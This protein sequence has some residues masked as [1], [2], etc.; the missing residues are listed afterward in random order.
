MNPSI[1]CAGSHHPYLVSSQKYSQHYVACLDFKDNTN[2]SLILDDLYEIGI[3]EFLECPGVE[4]KSPDTEADCL[5]MDHLTSINNFFMWSHLMRR[6]LFRPP[7]MT[8]IYAMQLPWQR[9]TL[10][11]CDH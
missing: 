8:C 6:H 4:L 10:C 3:L 11:S 5:P 7:S 2:C 9:E 1:Q